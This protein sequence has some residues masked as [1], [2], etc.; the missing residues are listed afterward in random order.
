MAIFPGSFICKTA[1]QHQYRVFLIPWVKRN[2]SLNCSNGRDYSASVPVRYIPKKS[3]KCKDSLLAK[4]LED[5][6]KQNTSSE[7]NVQTVEFSNNSHLSFVLN[8]KTL[9]HDRMPIEDEEEI[10]GN[11][12]DLDC[13]FMEETLEV[14]EELEINHG[15]DPG[16]KCR[17]IQSSKSKQEVEKLAIELLATR[18][19]TA[20][21][22][23]KK[24]LGKRCP[25]DSVDSVITDFQSRG[26]LDDCLYAETFSRSRWS[27]SSWGP[28]R[29]KQALLK[30][31]VNEIDAQKAIKL[32]FEDGESGGDQDSR[33]GISKSSIDRLFDQASKQWFRS[34]AVP[35]ETRKS[36]IVRWLQ[37]RGFSWNVV[38]F[39]LK[40]LESEYP[41]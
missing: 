23:K 34:R 37:Y 39:V 27:S 22:M 31:G 25:L 38:A 4:H 17:G 40:K 15:K 29:I 2:S 26:L 24:L 11:F 14:A 3:S 12:G 41:S 16:Q 32:V 21:E 9:D 28:R 7:L 1:I 13:E 19:F 18:A 35:L 8:P 30:K 33:I 5:R 20:M 6:E 10:E 36:R